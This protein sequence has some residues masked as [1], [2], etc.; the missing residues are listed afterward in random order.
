MLIE[1]SIMFIF[2][3]VLHNVIELDE[4]GDD[5]H[6]TMIIGDAL[7]DKNK[8]PMRY[9]TGWRNQVKVQILNTC[10]FFLYH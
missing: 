3:V 7:D 1:P 2:K 4:D 6:D 8:Q 5:P 9:D 10:L